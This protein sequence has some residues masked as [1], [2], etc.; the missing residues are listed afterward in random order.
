[1]FMLQ[2]LDEVRFPVCELIQLTLRL[3]IPCPQDVEHCKNTL[4]KL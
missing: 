1:M 2:I 4:V 3:L